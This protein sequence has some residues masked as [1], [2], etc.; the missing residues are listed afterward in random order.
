MWHYVPTGTWP[1]FLQLS[2]LWELTSYYLKGF[3]SLLLHEFVNR[4]ASTIIQ[5]R[6]ALDPNGNQIHPLRTLSSSSGCICGI[7]VR[8]SWYNSRD[9]CRWI[10]N[11]FI[12]IFQKISFEIFK[13]L[14][15][16][17]PVETSKKKIFFWRNKKIPVRVSGKISV[18][19][20]SCT[21]M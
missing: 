17:K 15:K 3:P 11:I 9:S 2:V 21:V 1:D 4:A 19:I 10:H 5:P 13:L 16:N 6:I 18:I 7:P 12:R 14:F 20:F 8:I